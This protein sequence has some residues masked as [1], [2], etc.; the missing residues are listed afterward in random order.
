MATLTPTRLAAL[1]A[2]AVLS[3]TALAACSDDD[4]DSPEVTIT[5]PSNGED[6]GSDVVV[7]WDAST[8]LGEPDTGRNHVHVF[9]DGE[10]NDYTVVGGNEF[11]VEGLSPGEHTINVTL[12]HADHS[13]AGA[14]DEVEVNV[15]AGGGSAEEPTEEPE[16]DEDDDTAPP[17]SYDY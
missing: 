12:Q 11:E 14:E 6:V 7:S 17:P 3:L 1:G 10:E 5:S 15:T 16:K 4:G 9:V 2:A 13:D 8:E